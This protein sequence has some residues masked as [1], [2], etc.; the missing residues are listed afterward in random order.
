MQK[1]VKLLTVVCLLFVF[2]LLLSG[3]VKGVVSEIFY[4][5]AFLLP[6]CAGL[7]LAGERKISTE[8]FRINAT[9]ARMSLPLLFPTVGLV[10][11][12]SYLSSAVIFA[13]FGENS[14]VDVGDSIFTAIIMHALLPAVLE[15]LLFRYLPMRLF[16]RT[17]PRFTIL[18][19][20]GCFALVHHSFFSMPY[21][22][23]AG[24]IFMALDLAAGSIIPSLIIHFI[25]NALSVLWIFY[26]GNGDFV[27]GFW[28]AL[29]ILSL[30]SL[31]YVFYL[32]REYR[33]YFRPVFCSDEPRV[34][35]YA[36][37]YLAVPMITLAIAELL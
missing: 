18:L 1:R 33:E 37:L 36:P 12:I 7:Y 27:L 21:A 9:G 11:L 16:S 22:F 17:A 6:L 28:I 34:A 30:L 3:T 26:S 14:S 19:S 24:L 2:I 23:V 32:R 4:F 5:L 13:V 15:E 25:N 35:T 10:F 31:L 8:E 20:A 29:G